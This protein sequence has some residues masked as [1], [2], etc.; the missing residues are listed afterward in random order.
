MGFNVKAV[1]GSSK[2]ITQPQGGGNKLQGI[3]GF[4][5]GNHWA[6]RAYQLRANGQGRN[7]LFCVN[8]LSNI[9]MSGGVSGRST[10]FSPSADGVHC[11]AQ[12][13]NVGLYRPPPPVL[14]STWNSWGGYNAV[15]QPQNEYGIGNP[16]LT[17]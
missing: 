4:G 8:Q 11:G 3:G 5:Y 17:Y 12:Y 9:G 1:T 6:T 14:R 10:M 7:L 15:P 2:I 16:R 13:G